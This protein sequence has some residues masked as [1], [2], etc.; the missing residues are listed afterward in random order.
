MRRWILQ[1]LRRNFVA[2]VALLLALSGT[3]YA[4]AT[5][6]IPANSVGTRQVIN[7]S[8]RS[9]DFRRGTLPGKLVV[10][11]T[12]AE[13]EVAP[14]AASGTVELTV[15]CPR[16]QVAVGGG[17]KFSDAR[18]EIFNADILASRRVPNGW[19]VKAALF[20]GTGPPITTLTAYAY[21][22]RGAAIAAG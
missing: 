9:V 13:K 14:Y 5:K 8:L 7:H 12:S 15:V 4:A 1:H 11:E 17:W 6:L 16:G 21:C 18:Q 22:V 3:S 2:Y 10:T 20:Q 19:L